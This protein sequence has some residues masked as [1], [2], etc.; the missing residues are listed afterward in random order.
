M[1]VNSN[2]FLGHWV[3]ELPRSHISLLM[4]HIESIPLIIGSRCW[5]QLI[6][7]EL[8]G[9][10]LW[11][12]VS[13]RLEY[14]LGG[15]D[16]LVLWLGVI[17]SHTWVG[18]LE[19][20]VNSDSFNEVKWVFLVEW[21]TEFSF[22]VKLWNIN[23]LL[24]W[25]WIILSR[26]N[27]QSWVYL[28]LSWVNLESIRLGNKS[29]DDASFTLTFQIVLFFNWPRI[30]ISTWSWLTIKVLFQLN[31]GIKSPLLNTKLL[32]LLL[33]GASVGKG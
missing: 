24:Y 17:V 2:N 3:L 15:W 1:E 22:W 14:T 13:H 27:I 4:N 19:V 5:L 31:F 29:I 7:D 28:S 16:R 12:A 33:F 9:I 18:L 23:V 6:F 20:N 32:F 11:I 30:L 21:K 26:T 10:F 25:H 8:S